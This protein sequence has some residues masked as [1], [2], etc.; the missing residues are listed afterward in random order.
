MP[1]SCDRSFGIHVARIA[2]F[3]VSVVSEAGELADALERGESP[4]GHLVERHA[5]RSTS[6]TEQLD[7]LG[8]DTGV[9]AGEFNSNRALHTR[10]SSSSNKR[11]IVDEAQDNHEGFTSYVNEAKE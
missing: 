7:S 5:T 11:K 3:P 4:Q 2:D 9:T 10:V 1:G 6:Q 8:E